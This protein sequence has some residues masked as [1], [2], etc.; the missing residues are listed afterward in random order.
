MKNTVRIS[1]DVPV[2]EHILYKTEC[3]RTRIP[4]KD[5]V[6]NLVK[7]GMQEYQKEQFDIKMKKSL[8]QAKKGKV[9]T[10]SLEELDRWET[11]LENGTE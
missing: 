8:L 11:E 6:H 4:V 3:V 10:V 1:F 9:R 7:L 5:F 2:D